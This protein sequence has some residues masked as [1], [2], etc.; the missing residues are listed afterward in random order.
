MKKILVIEDETPVRKNLVELLDAEGYFPLEAGDGEQGVRVAWENLPDLILCDI[1]MPKM[2][3]FGVLARLSR[4]PLTSTIPFIFITARTERE[5]LRRGMVMGA[6]DYI[7]K[8]FSLD[9]V[10][11]AIETRLEK[12]A[13]IEQRAEKKLAELHKSTQMSLPA[14]LLNPLSMIFG[15]SELLANRQEA[16]QLDMG[17]VSSIA[18]EISRSAAR[19]LRSLQEYLLLNEL[20]AIEADPERLRLLRENRVASSLEAISDTAYFKAVQDGRDSDLK[21]DVEETPLYFSE[22]HL[23]KVVEE[24][25]DYAFRTS[26]SGSPVEISGR[27][28]PD[29]RL[30]LL[31]VTDQGRGLPPDQLAWLAGPA[32]PNLLSNE[33]QQGIGLAIVR[34]L[35]NLHGGSFNVQ[36]QPGQ[37]T[38]VEVQIP[39]CD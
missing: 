29:R 4:D 28:H 25:L 35:V 31:R 26:P 24:M 1:N 32:Q 12:R 16:A 18:Q 33:G 39:Q 3:G 38:I 6:D 21:I 13:M 23:Q 10:I 15:A 19:L 37:W 17:Q 36:S 8:P 22:V 30:Y 2:D 34:R 7:T 14:E 11:R 20:E 27:V 5:D 9:D